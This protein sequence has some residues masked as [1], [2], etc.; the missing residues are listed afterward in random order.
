MSEFNKTVFDK[1]MLELHARPRPT[2]M[3]ASYQWVWALRQAFLRRDDRLWRK[4]N[5]GK[6]P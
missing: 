4:R 3:L 2:H 5:W 6:K 1:I